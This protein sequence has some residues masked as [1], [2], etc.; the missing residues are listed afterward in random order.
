MNICRISWQLVWISGPFLGMTTQCQALLTVAKEFYLLVCN[1][2][3]WVRW[4]VTKCKHVIWLKTS[5]ILVR[6]LILLR[7]IYERLKISCALSDAAAVV[8]CVVWWR[9]LFYSRSVVPTVL[10]RFTNIHRYDCKKIIESRAPW[11]PCFWRVP[12]FWAVAVI[13]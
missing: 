4:K 7:L 6:L 13:G 12:W 2:N 8:V 3:T 11:I 10:S 5:W 1:L 9:R